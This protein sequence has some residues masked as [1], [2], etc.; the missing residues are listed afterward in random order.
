MSTPPDPPQDP[1]PGYPGSG[2][3]QVEPPPG[4]PLVPADL[5]GWFERIAGVVRRSF[6]TLIQIHLGLALVSI[7]VGLTLGPPFDGAPINP[8]TFE[9][10]E[11]AGLLGGMAIGFAVLFV[12]TAFAVG[13]SVFVVVRDAAGQPASVGEALGFAV[14]RALPLIGWGLL[15]ALAIGAGTLLLVLPG[16]YLAVV[17]LSTLYGVVV[18]ERRGI[19]RCFTL[20]HNRFG[21]TV[22]RMALVFLAGLV[23]F[24]VVSVVA[25]GLGQGSLA[26]LVVQAVIN[27]GTGV[28]AIGVYV[29]TYA[30][31]RFREHP[32]VSTPSLAAEL[33]R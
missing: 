26:A 29:V 25:A 17:L 33:N 9:T 8:R 23:V 6:G 22:G 12:A 16:L 10:G 7:L 5:G 24:G 11:L 19:D 14:G 21:P 31:L 32:G 27:A 13:A 2:Y 3:G 4:D 15:A 18:I 30:E 1:F 28:V 20:V